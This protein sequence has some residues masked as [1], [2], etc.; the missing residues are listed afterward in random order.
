VD[1]QYNTFVNGLVTDITDVNAPENSLKESVNMDISFDG[2]IFR[3][4]SLKSVADLTNPAVRNLTTKYLYKIWETDLGDK[5]RVIIQIQEESTVIQ[6]YFG[7]YDY[8]T[9]AQVKVVNK[10]ASS[11][12]SVDITTG[13]NS[14]YIAT[15]TDLFYI[16]ATSLGVISDPEDISIKV[17]D[18][19][20]ISTGLSLTNRPPNIGQLSDDRN[21][22][23]MTNSGWGVTINEYSSGTSKKDY[24]HFF[25]HFGAYPSR[26]DSPTYAIQENPEASDEKRFRASNIDASY[27]GTSAAPTGSILVHLNDGQATLDENNI[28]F[29]LNAVSLYNLG[30]CTYDKPTTVA[31][32]SGRLFFAGV[33]GSVEYAST[34]FFSRILTNNNLAGECYQEADPTSS[35][36]S[37][38][39]D[40]DGGSIPIP[41]ANNI[42]K[43]EVYKDT[44]LVFADNGVWAV[45]SGADAGFTATSYAVYKVG[46]ITPL[47]GS[48]SLTEFGVAFASREGVFTLQ[49]DKFSGTLVPTNILTGKVQRL[50]NGLTNTQRASFN[51]VYD[52]SN[53]RLLMSYEDSTGNRTKALVFNAILGAYYEYVFSTNEIGYIT[54][55][56]TTFY[57][58]SKEDVLDSLGALVTSG[59]ESVTVPVRLSQ[60]VPTSV[61]FLLDTVAGLSIATLTGVDYIDDTGTLFDS[62][63][64]TNP[65]VFKD[66]PREKQVYSLVCQFKKTETGYL[67]D[68]NGGMVLQNPSSCL[69]Q[70]RWDFSESSGTGKFGREYQAYR[71]KRLHIPDETLAFDNYTVV[72]SK[73]KLR[74]SGKALQ[75]SFKAEGD[76]HLNMLGYALDVKHRKTI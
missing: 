41:E 7:F 65:S 48:I 56:P 52:S 32:N 59:G 50:Y 53:K 30:K 15:G 34:I 19:S 67:E 25:D 57:V 18:F 64:M 27:L 47:S 16:E 14:C 51:L 38:L 68:A 66:L 21:A 1:F 36:I 74:G 12:D 31:L 10:Q 71:H 49:P 61:E 58:A 63:F 26:A 54:E 17:R 73:S 69:V 62:H 39:V 55:S 24:E 3:R 9:N 33:K 35:E 75:L 13:K 22:Y 29:W 2:S 11:F 23:N 45:A 70:S 72:E 6:A 60:N 40:T 76:K 46:D 28:P 5:Y 42:F 4:N 44:L 43:L 20:G 8:S 37:D